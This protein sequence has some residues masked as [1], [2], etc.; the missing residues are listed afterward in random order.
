MLYRVEVVIDETI[1]FMDPSRKRIKEL[2]TSN[3]GVLIRLEEGWKK[4]EDGLCEMRFKNL[5][6]SKEYIKK[7]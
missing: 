7:F 5:A 1:W 2:E 6:I 4:A 3:E